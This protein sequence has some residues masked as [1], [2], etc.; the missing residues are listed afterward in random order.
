MMTDSASRSACRSIGSVKVK[1]ELELATCDAEGCRMSSLLLTLGSTFAHAAETRLRN[2]RS[3][4]QASLLGSKG[5][6]YIHAIAATS[7]WFVSSSLQR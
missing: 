6:H 3:A 2:F 7:P 5:M 4:S 1:V